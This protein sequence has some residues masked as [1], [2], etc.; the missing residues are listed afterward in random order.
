MTFPGLL[1]CDCISDSE[2][3]FVKGSVGYG[4]EEGCLWAGKGEMDKG[5]PESRGI[6]QITW[7]PG[8][9]A[10]DQGTLKVK[11]NCLSDV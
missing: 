4:V 9:S 2:P 11:G 1:V 10:G 5:K 6:T 8:N 3:L 7:G